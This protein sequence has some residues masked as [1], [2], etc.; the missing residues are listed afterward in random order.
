MKFHKLKGH[1]DIWF[2]NFNYRGEHS[3]GDV[4]AATDEDILDFDWGKFLSSNGVK[5]H[6]IYYISFIT[7]HEWNIF[8][9]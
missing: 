3:Y 1:K 9:P 5:D 7:C 2:Y 8:I 4:F 6:F